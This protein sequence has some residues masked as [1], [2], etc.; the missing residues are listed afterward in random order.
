MNLFGPHLDLFLL[1]LIHRNLTDP[2]SLRGIAMS[3]GGT[4]TS[5]R[6]RTLE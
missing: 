3:Q 6:M 2:P 5:E 1:M 4:K